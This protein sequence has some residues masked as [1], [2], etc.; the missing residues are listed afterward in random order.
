MLAIIEP[1]IEKA[2]IKTLQVFMHRG[3]F[4]LRWKQAGNRF[5]IKDNS[6]SGCKTIIWYLKVIK[7]N[8]MFIVSA[9]REKISTEFIYMKF[10]Y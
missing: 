2:A 7:G 10:Q 8:G 5:M 3:L 6:P 9:R 1:F 4:A